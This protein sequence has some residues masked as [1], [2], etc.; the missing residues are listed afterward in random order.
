MKTNRVPIWV[1]YLINK[2]LIKN[3]GFIT[4]CVEDCFPDSLM[5]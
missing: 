5:K 3:Y 4:L 1:P 2:S